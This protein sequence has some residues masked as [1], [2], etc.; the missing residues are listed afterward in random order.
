MLNFGDIVTFFSFGHTRK[1]WY[2]RRCIKAQKSGSFNI[3]EFREGEEWNQTM[4]GLLKKIV[5]DTN[6][7]E[8]KKLYKVVE[9]INHLEPSV[10]GLSNEQLAARTIEFKERLAN[11]EPL[12]DLLPET[13]AVVRE[14]AKRVLGKRHYDVQLLGGIVLHQGRIAEMRTGEGKTLVA[15]LPSYLNALTG[16]G[17]HVITVNDYLARRDAEEMGQVH[18]FLGLQVGLN[19]NGME[20]A[21]KKTSVR[22]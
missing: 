3:D 1:G 5:G 4:I 11:G 16:K 6:E 17:V 15:T 12:D 9:I 14:T 18:R 7:R 13:Y 21:Q 10:A 19:I 22:L 8:V 2:T 20:P